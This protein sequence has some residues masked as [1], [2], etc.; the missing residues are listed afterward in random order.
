[1]FIF[2]SIMRVTSNESLVF[3]PTESSAKAQNKKVVSCFWHVIRA[4]YIKVKFDDVSTAVFC[5]HLNISYDS[6]VVTDI[7]YCTE[8]LALLYP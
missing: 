2:F 6:V 4:V 5:C 3:D 1:M 8:R 7:G